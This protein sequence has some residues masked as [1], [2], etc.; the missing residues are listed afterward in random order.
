MRTVKYVA[1]NTV[2]LLESG[3]QFFPALLAAIDGAE[4]DILFET[5]IWATDESSAKVEAAL[6]AAAKR[7]VKVRVV[8]D[9]FGASN[10]ARRT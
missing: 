1:N 10:Y 4:H 5:Y 9:W 6:I 3:V 8:V 2:T 7:G